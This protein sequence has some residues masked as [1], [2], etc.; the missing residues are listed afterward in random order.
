MADDP[1]S[2]RPPN[3]GETVAA[4]TATS[5]D[6][7]NIPAPYALGQLPVHSGPTRLDT[8]LNRLNWL[9][10][11]EQQG[12][13][14]PPVSDTDTPTPTTPVPDNWLTRLFGFSGTVVTR[15]PNDRPTQ[16]IS[17]PEYWPQGY[18]P[19]TTTTTTTTP[20]ANVAGTSNAV[21]TWWARLLGWPV[22]TVKE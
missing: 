13:Y 8:A 21:R 3:L 20:G 1:S 9:V 17:P 19:S 4:V 10:P 14:I 16:Q 11:K 7:R 18:N 6:Q 22:P 15:A 12:G 2:T 5:F